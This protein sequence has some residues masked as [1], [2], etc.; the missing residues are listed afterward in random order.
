MFRRDSIYDAM[1]TPILLARCC[2]TLNQL[3]YLPFEPIMSDATF[4]NL[5]ALLDASMDDLEDLPPIG[6]P[7]SGHYNLTVSFS[8]EAIGEEKKEVICASYIVE[9]INE[10]KNQDESDEVAVGQQFKEFF[11]ITKRDGTANTF[12]I[13]T[14]KARLA[15]HAV[16]FG[17]TS[18]RELVAAVNQVAITASIKRTVNKKNEDQ[19]NVQLKDIVLL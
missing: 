15:P 1:T 13:G 19:H 14:L 8:I 10:L 9:A 3:T 18:I 6:V 16:R 2:L 4:N 7:P 11:H 17:T 12:G 5:D